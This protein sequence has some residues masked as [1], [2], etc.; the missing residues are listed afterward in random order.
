MTSSFQV[1]G[2]LI[3]V[4]SQGQI[5]PKSDHLYGHQ[6]QT[7]THGQKVKGTGLDTCYN[8]VYVSQTQEEQ[9]FTISKVAADWHELMIM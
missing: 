4:K 7:Q 2:N 1:I 3:K 8:A 6:T 5:S 9:R